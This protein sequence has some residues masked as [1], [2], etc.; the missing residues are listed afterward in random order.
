MKYLLTLLLITVMVV[1]SFGQKARQKQTSG[2]SLKGLA[3]SSQPG[4]QFHDYPQ[5]KSSDINRSVSLPPV[6]DNSGQPYLRSVFSQRGASCGQAASV[7]YN[8]CYEINRLRQISS[9]TITNTYPDHFT[10]NFMNGTLPYYGEG[11]SYFHTFDILYD[12]GN[13]TEAVYGPITMDD[14]YYWM[15]GYE[16]YHSAMFNRISGVNSIPVGTPKGLEILKHWL[17]NHLENSDVGGIANF[18]AGIISPVQLPSGSPEAGK[19]VITQWQPTASHAMTIVGYNDSIRFDRNGDGVFTN[20]ID[21][22]NDGVVDMKDWEIGGLKFVN[23]YG[24]GWGND[25]FCY[26]LYSTLAIKYGQGGIWN[27]SVHVITPDIEYQPF[28]TI[29]ASITYNKRGRIKISA[30]ISSDTSRFVPEHSM[31]FSIFNFQGRDFNMTGSSHPDGKNLEFGLDITPLLSFIESDNQARIF[32]IIDETDPNH[33]AE[34]FI[35]D[36]QV[37][38]Y[39][40][41][42]PVFYSGNDVPSVIT[43]NGRTLLSA[44]ITNNTDIPLLIA[45]DVHLVTPGTGYSFSASVSGGN[46]PFEWETQSIYHTA[47]SLSVYP[48][49]D[50]QQLIPGNN[51]SGFAEVPLPFSF[52]FF[53][54]QYDT[55][56]MHVNGYLMFERA[57]MPYYY[58]L[59]DELY[60]NQ[61]RAVAPFMNKNLGLNGSSDF[62]KCNIKNDK[63]VFWWKVSNAFETQS[64]EFSVELNRNGSISFQYG[65]VSLNSLLPLAGISSGTSRAYIPASGNSSFPAEG[66]I[67]RFFPSFPV[68]NASVDAEGEVNIQIPEGFTFGTFRLSVTDKNRLKADKIITL[69]T[70]PELVISLA[71]SSL[72]LSPGSTI[73]LSVKIRNLG[74]Q[75]IENAGLRLSSASSN[76]NIVGPELTGITIPVGETLLFNNKFSIKIPDSISSVQP[77]RVL[78][79]LIFAE[80]KILTFATFES[81]LPLLL[82]GPPGVSDSNNGIADPGESVDL[83]FDIYNVGNATAGNVTVTL[84]L[85]SPYAALCGNHSI[86]FGELGPYSKK[87]IGF[88]VQVNEGTPSGKIINLSLSVNSE[89]AGIS[90]ETYRLALGS[91]EI[92]LID[93]DSNHNSAVHI[94]GAIESNYLSCNIFETIDSLLFDYKILFLS[95]GFFNQNYKLNPEEDALLVGFLNRGGKLYIEGGAF[96]KQDQAT[97]LRSKLGVTG[98]TQAWLTPPDTLLGYVNTEAQEFK[99]DY[100]GEYIRGENL[101]PNGT[102]EPWLYDKNSGLNFVVVQDSGHYKTIS[103]SVEFGGFFMF[104][105]PGRP[106]LVSKYLEF[107]DY[108]TESLCASFQPSTTELCPGNSVSFTSN[109]SRLP[110]TWMWTFPGGT[111]NTWNGPDPQIQYNTPGF[112]SVSLTVSDGSENN[113]FV[114]DDIIHVNEC[115]GINELNAH[116]LKIYP[117]PANDKVT[118]ESEL[119]KGNTEIRLL[120]SKGV[121]VFKQLIQSGDQSIYLSLPQLKK[122]FYIIRIYS[123][124]KI[125]W[126]KLIIQ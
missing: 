73:P 15:S 56:F 17:H 24:P 39:S 119:I 79:E 91:P 109:Y 34:G 78:A 77:L 68:E 114:I 57:D 40:G 16:K 45:T 26:M 48:E 55:V 95:L 63:A 70:G 35:S 117:N 96:F 46:A 38:S 82:L 50:G 54:Q 8:F 71:D 12:A 107:L 22:N 2:L 88:P 20:H 103:S 36:F 69:T 97:V 75:T 116:S 5:L 44:V 121:E 108:P 123:N 125:L 85:E 102:A 124:N 122:G 33:S 104:D 65:E 112:Y 59:F 42:E 67:K 49:P 118:I 90:E 53:G 4:V 27:N 13:P 3:R 58:L 9:D 93:K 80:T 76:H 41:Q 106:E 92:A 84:S 89:L 6:V 21:I 110:A 72:L 25:G 30:G 113:T 31:D 64:V 100:R 126:S 29:K 51:Q 66:E 7:A 87:R 10:W 52:N 23:S 115:L 81:A 99:I 94:A 32:L 60:F 83:F 18:Y 86:S 111:P 62:L 120:D 28:L 74:N 1:G 14:S 61:I 101:I 37:I 43:D 19:A 98:S 47:D 11:V 105:S